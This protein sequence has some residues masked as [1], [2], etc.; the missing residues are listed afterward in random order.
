MQYKLEQGGSRGAPGNP[1]I[2]QKLRHK[3]QIILVTLLP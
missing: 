1:R 2:L 3:R